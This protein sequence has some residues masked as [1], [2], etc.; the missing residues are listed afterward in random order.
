MVKQNAY[1]N[2][3]I[4]QTFEGALRELQDYDDPDYVESITCSIGEQKK[5]AQKIQERMHSKFQEK[6]RVI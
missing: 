3:R 4:N 2:D 5:F 1:F 6:Q